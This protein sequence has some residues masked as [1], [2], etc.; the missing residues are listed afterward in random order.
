VKFSFFDR[1][2]IIKCL[3]NQQFDV[4]VI[5][6]GITGVGIALDAVTR[7]LTTALVDMQDFS[8]GTSSRSTK[9]VHGGL[10]YLK[11]FEL[12]IVSEVGKERAVVYE[13]G[14]HV[15]KPEWM[16][17]PIHQGGTFGRYTTSIGLKLYDFLAGVTKKERRMMLNRTETLEKEPMLKKEGL[18][19]AGYY[20]EYRTD[21]ARLTIEVIKEAVDQG[22]IA[23]NYA[24]VEEFLFH[25]QKLVGA[26]I[27]DVLTGEDFTIHAKIVVNAAG[28]W[29]DMVRK[30]IPSKHNKSLK[31]SKGVHIVL[32]QSRFPLQ[33]AIYFDTPDSRMVFAI[34]RDGK[35]YVGTTDTFCNEV[36]AKPKISI[37]DRQYLIEAVNGMFPELVLSV[38]EIESSW[39]GIRPLI[40]QEGRA[41]SEISR[42]DEIWESSWGLLSIAGGKLT[43][44]RRMA[45]N[46]VDLI[47]NKLNRQ[48]KKTISPCRT[49]KLSI[50]GG[51]VG[52]P[53]RFQYFV[54]KNIDRGMQIGLSN[55][56]AKSLASIYGSNIGVI[57]SLM[58]KQQ[59]VRGK[60][61]IP[62]FLLAR[63][64]YG[65]EYEM[66]V[67]PVDF[68]MR[69]TGM[70][71]FNID[72]VLEWK[73]EV[74]AYMAE[75][76]SWSN[77]QTKFYRNELSL[78]IENATCA[79][80]DQ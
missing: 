40:L 21:D 39:A 63:L 51:R 59:I 30:G 15:T 9:L 31:L 26:K 54:D 19:G 48:E 2:K 53:S 73:D 25:N 10:R 34:P 44:Y 61:K 37:Q 50:S 55:K 8:A 67:T 71:L 12:K 76:F 27:V 35:T 13:N 75:I 43:G 7:G 57:Y 1:D 65:I 70:I 16:L 23:L 6:G 4:L 49:K 69:R 60:T 24:K 79:K 32:P 74:I 36:T 20:V 42:K 45:E 62:T 68:F 78:E 11:Q 52:G 47:S 14:P 77:Q 46:I 22:A 5:G 66:I 41:P 64:I 38:N 17:L 18:K 29:V 58:E 28:P 80:E 33:Q 3:Q 72:E 56:E